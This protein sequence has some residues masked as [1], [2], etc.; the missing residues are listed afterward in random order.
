MTIKVTKRSNT[1]IV[2]LNNDNGSN[3]FKVSVTGEASSVAG[4]LNDL[5]DFN[6]TGVQN[7]YIIMYD[8]ATQKY[9]A[10]SPDDVLSKSVDGGLPTNFVNQ[11]DTDLDNKIDLDAG[12]F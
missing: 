3:N 9:V 7:G 1:Y 2:K 12:T 8:S 10:A 4:N 5:D 11:L 6:P